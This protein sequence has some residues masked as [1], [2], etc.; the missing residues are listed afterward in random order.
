V[1]AIRVTTQEALDAHAMQ[2]LAQATVVTNQGGFVHNTNDLLLMLL[3]TAVSNNFLVWKRWMNGDV[4]ATTGSNWY[5]WN[6]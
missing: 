4:D 5:T 2:G 6:K 1:L 3:S